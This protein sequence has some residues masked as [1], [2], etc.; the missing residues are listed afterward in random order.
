ML[1]H[2]QESRRGGS[3]PCFEAIHSRYGDYCSFLKGFPAQYS[4]DYSSAPRR[5]LQALHHNHHGCFSGSGWVFRSDQ[6]LLESL[7]FDYFNEFDADFFD[8]FCFF[9]TPSFDFQQRPVQ[10]GFLLVCLFDCFAGCF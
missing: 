1:S 2:H 6:V 3:V 5:G 10:Q 4:C 9:S 8:N 7:G